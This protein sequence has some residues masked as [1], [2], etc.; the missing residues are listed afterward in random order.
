MNGAAANINNEMGSL[1]IKEYGAATYKAPQVIPLL[2]MRTVAI[3]CEMKSLQSGAK[4]ILVSHVLLTNNGW[5]KATIDGSPWFAHQLL[6]QKYVAGINGKNPGEIKSAD[7][8]YVDEPVEGKELILSLILNGFQKSILLVLKNPYLG[9]NI[10]GCTKDVA[11][12]SMDDFVADLVLIRR[13]QSQGTCDII[14]EVCKSLTKNVTA[15]NLKTGGLV[16][17]NFSGIFFGGEKGCVNSLAHKVVGS[18]SLSVIM[19][20]AA[21]DFLKKNNVKVPENKD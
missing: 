17:G 20:S 10:I 4:F 14:E 15:L 9:A 11:V 2:E 7:A 5:F 1:T 3:S 12:I 8:N 18:F 21:A 16:E 19:A 13:Q 6:D